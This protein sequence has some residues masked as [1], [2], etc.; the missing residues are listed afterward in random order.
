MPVPVPSPAPDTCNEKK[1]GAGS[2]PTGRISE[3]AAIIE[4]LYATIEK[5]VPSI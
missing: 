3:K 2:T 5:M 1:T 4:V